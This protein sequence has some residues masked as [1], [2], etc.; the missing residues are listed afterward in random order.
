[1]FPPKKTKLTRIHPYQNPYAYENEKQ[2][3][4]IFRRPMRHF[5][6]DPP[7]YPWVCPEPLV[8]FHLNFKE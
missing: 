1:M 3:S 2:L 5:E 6:E 8:N 7:F 4:T